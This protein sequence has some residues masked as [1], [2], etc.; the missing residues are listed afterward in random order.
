M[1]RETSTVRSDW[2]AQCESDGFTFHTPEGIPYWD[3]SVCFRF[4]EKQIET[5]ETA[6]EIVNGMC[7]EVVAKTIQS[8]NYHG[9]DL[10]PRMVELVEQSWKDGERAVYGRFDLAYTGAGMPKFLEYNADTPTSLFEAAVVQWKWLQAVKPDYDQFN[11]I[12]EKL[13]NCWR[14]RKLSLTNPFHFA[15]SDSEED[16]CNL[17]YLADTA[18]QAGFQDVRLCHM[19]DFFES[20][21][22]LTDAD[23][24]VITQMFK[25]YPWEWMMNEDGIKSLNGVRVIEPAWK[26]LLSCKELMVRLYEN[27]PNSPYILPAYR[28][29]NAYC[30]PRSYVSKP[31]Y[32]REGQ[33]VRMDGVANE[34]PLI[35]ATSTRR[36]LQEKTHLFRSGDNYSV[37]GSWVIGDE[38]A[39]IGIREDN[40][41][42]TKNHSRF[43][44]HYF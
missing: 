23:D 2:K 36:I 34:S 5:L 6:T 17:A 28:D 27:F 25:L 16:F 39:G 11:S 1:I 33:G 8:G 26:I 20:Y 43:I 44:P 35:E 15:S 10:T 14:N 7:L 19:E 21:G 12:H 18:V 4:T 24:Q 3:E 32:S 9:Y 31:I 13:I 37:I 42:I 29:E 22:F 40:S 38:P 30:F 41:P